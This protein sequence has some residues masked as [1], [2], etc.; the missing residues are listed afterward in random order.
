MGKDEKYVH[1]E[2]SVAHDDTLGAH[3]VY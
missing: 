2:I 3:E 1:G